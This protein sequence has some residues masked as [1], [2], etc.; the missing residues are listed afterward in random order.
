[1][2]ILIIVIS[3]VYLMIFLSLVSSLF[4]DV[5]DEPDRL[6]IRLLFCGIS[7]WCSVAY[8]LITSIRNII[9]E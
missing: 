6:I 1:M 8:P 5:F 2:D 4:D 9:G 3:I 7:L